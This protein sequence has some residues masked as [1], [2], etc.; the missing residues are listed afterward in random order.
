MR[1]ERRYVHRPI[2]RCVAAV[3]AASAAFVVG[4]VGIAG[5]VVGGVVADLA[6]N[7]HL[8]G[9]TLSGVGKMTFMGGDFYEV[10]LN[11]HHLPLLPPPHRASMRLA[12]VQGLA[13]TALLT[14]AFSRAR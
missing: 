3:A 9:N 1:A 12:A 10:S 4:V 11:L 2:L 6:F 7:M 14:V 8:S 5:G 13:S